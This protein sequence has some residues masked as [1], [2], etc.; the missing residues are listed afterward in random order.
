MSLTLKIVTQEAPNE[1]HP[2][3]YIVTEELIGISPE[4]AYKY[5]EEEVLDIPERR[6]DTLDEYWEDEWKSFERNEENQ[7]LVQSMLDNYNSRYDFWR[8]EKTD[9][10]F[11]AW[12]K[13]L[14]SP[15]FTIQCENVWIEVFNNDLPQKEDSTNG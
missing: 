11:K 6:W 10:A 9:E 4:E 14:K 7:Q 1:F 3:N 12:L 5:I 2:W 8:G 13:N 15:L